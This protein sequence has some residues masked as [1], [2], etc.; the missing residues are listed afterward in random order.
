MNT[1]I[2]IKS[3]FANIIYYSGITDKVIAN[4]SKSQYLI[5]MY[6][7]IIPYKE[8]VPGLQAGMY[9][10][11]ETFKMHVQ[12]LKNYFNVIPLFEIPLYLKYSNNTSNEKPVCVLTF[13]DGWYNFYKYAYPI[14]MKHE[15]PATVF[16][17]TKYIGTKYRFWT[18]TLT[19]LCYGREQGEGSNRRQPKSSNPVIDLLENGNGYTE[20][21][22]ERA[23]ETMKA[24][25]Q[26]EIKRI[27]ASLSERWGIDTT[28]RT[29]DFLTW[30][31]VR[32]MRRSD[33]VSFGSHTDT[34][35]ILTMLTEDEIEEELKTSKDKLTAEGAVDSSFLPFAYPNGN[36]NRKIM[37]LLKKHK[38]S[39][40][41]TTR[42]GWNHFSDDS[43]N[44]EL[45][46]IGIHQDMAFSNS[47][48]GCRVL[49][50]I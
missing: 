13:D 28:P 47:M 10:D 40:A 34:H 32:E 38:Y 48:F 20:N 43:I 16:L 25:P 11:P 42:K 26:K 15:I 21:R 3:I 23:I 8:A 5:L 2:K 30:D 33:F 6:H 27:L 36:Y 44:F 17:P 49:Q 12:Y 14:L 9:V 22:M 46:R 45:N 37:A 41:V 19:Q 4:K 50:F 7:R 24:L 1:M 18:D 29:R 39:L 35:R 31:E